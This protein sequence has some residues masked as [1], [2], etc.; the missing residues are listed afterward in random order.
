MGLIARDRATWMNADATRDAPRCGPE[1]TGPAEPGGAA[2]GSLVAA[3]TRDDSEE[4][5]RAVHRQ[6]SAHLSL[7]I[8]GQLSWR[9]C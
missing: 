4:D 6:G 8:C 3:L 9:A 1:E 7:Y 2:A 5:A